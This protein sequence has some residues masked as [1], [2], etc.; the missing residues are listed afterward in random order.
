MTTLARFE[1]SPVFAVVGVNDRELLARQAVRREYERDQTVVLFGD[2]WAFLLFVEKGELQAY[3]ESSDGRSL[4]VAEFKKG[5]VFWGAALFSEN[6]PMPVTLETRSA[7]SLLLWRR[8]DIMPVLVRNGQA[9]W[10]L[11]RLMAE[12]M[13]RASM[14]VE[15]LAFRTVAGRVA[16]LLLEQAQ[17]QDITPRTLTL[18]EMAMRIGSTREMVCRSMQRFASDGLIEITRTEF[19]IANRQGLEKMV[20]IGKG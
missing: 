3:K 11:C 15:E 17:D 16:R 18:E 20:E 7:S 1:E 2:V 10:E 6:A 12:R 13:L 9:G 8:E 5:D 14:I 19:F 4:M